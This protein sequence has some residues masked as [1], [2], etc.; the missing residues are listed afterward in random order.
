MNKRMPI[1][2]CLS[3]LLAAA[4]CTISVPYDLD[5]PRQI[6]VSLDVTPDD[7]DVLLNGRFIG[8][9]NEFATRR[10]ALRL[11]SRYN[12]IVLHRIGY[13]DEV[14]DLRDYTSNTIALRITM[15]RL[16]REKPQVEPTPPLPPE[17]AQPQTE[18]PPPPPSITTEQA[19]PAKPEPTQPPKVEQ[20]RPAEKKL[21]LEALPAKATQVVLEITPEECAIYINGKFWGLSPEK[22]KIENLR[23]KPGKYTIEIFKAGFQPFRKEFAIPAQETFEISIALKQ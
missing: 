1:L 5:Q 10:T 17:P 4:A 6:Q 2:L 19:P 14:I 16:G 13:R 7:A 8:T 20:P 9:A 22:G 15:Q 23:L 11:A 12:E 18:E 3:L 21:P